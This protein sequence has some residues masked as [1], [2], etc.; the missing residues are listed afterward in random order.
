M[1]LLPLE[2]DIEEM[3]Y[4]INLEDGTGREFY[5]SESVALVALDA[6]DDTPPLVCKTHKQVEKQLGTLR[7]QY[8]ATCQLYALEKGEFEERREELRQPPPA[9]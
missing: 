2:P 1:I 4:V 9:S 6:P 8:P 7:Q 3:A 5:V